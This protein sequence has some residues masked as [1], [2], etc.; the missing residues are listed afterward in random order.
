MPKQTIQP[1]KN[2]NS[3]DN[4]LKKKTAKK[5]NLQEKI[6]TQK[7]HNTSQKHQKQRNKLKQ[8]NEKRNNSI[9]RGLKT[10]CHSQVEIFFSS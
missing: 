7:T 9:K 5:F 10:F 8:Q 2:S 1:K 6:P 4:E 3:V